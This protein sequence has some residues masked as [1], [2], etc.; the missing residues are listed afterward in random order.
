M[1]VHIIPNLARAADKHLTGFANILRKQHYQHVK[2]V[3]LSIIEGAGTLADVSRKT[4]V[5]SRTLEHFFHESFFNDDALLSH[6][7]AMMAYRTPTRSTRDAFLILDF[8]ATKTGEKQ[9]WADWLWDEETDTPSLFGHEQLLAVEFHPGKKYRKGLGFR[10]FYHQGVLKQSE[11]WPEDF[12]KKSVVAS[13]LLKAVRPQTKANEVLV[14]GEFIN[15]FLVNRLEQQQFDWTGRIK[16]SLLVVYQGI[17]DCRPRRLELL[18]EELEQKHQ[19]KWQKVRYRNQDIKAARIQVTIPSLSDRE[20][21]IAIC[22][23]SQGKL[24]FLATSRLQRGAGE[25]V[26]VYGYRWEIEVFIRDVKQALAFGDCRMRRVGA[27][28]RWQILCLVAANVMELIKKTKLELLMKTKTTMY[29]WFSSSVKRLY[30]VT[31]LTLGVTISLVRDLRNGGRELLLALKRNLHLNIAKKFLY[32][33]VN[34][35]RV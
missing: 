3:V 10:R 5:P 14:D 31:E 23:N 17:K 27:N 2:K 26:K 22:R 28:T 4:G 20:A 9:E 15:G 6:S 35:A 25:I 16:K 32:T 24:A 13:R 18:A 11:Y 33:G 19:L 34:F 12:E 8:T 30:Q 7:A 29:R 21:T 1:P